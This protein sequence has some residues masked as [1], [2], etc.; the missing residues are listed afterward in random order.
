[1]M[2]GP[3]QVDVSVLAALPNVTLAGPR[4]HGALP[5]YAQHWTAGLIPFRD[6]AQI[7]ACNPLKLREYLAAGRPVVATPFPALAPYAAEVAV[8]TDPAGFAA[9]LQAARAEPAGRADARRALVAGE[10]WEAQAAVA[11]RL[12]DGLLG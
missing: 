5:G 9:A 12:I 3:A 1:V 11:R 10:S 8:A 2:I 4:P 6:T 7:R